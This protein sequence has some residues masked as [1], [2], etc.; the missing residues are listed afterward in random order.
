LN[1]AI[2]LRGPANEEISGVIER[3]TFDNHDSG[4]R[5]LWVKA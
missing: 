2:P 1:A 4:F 5:I 3:V